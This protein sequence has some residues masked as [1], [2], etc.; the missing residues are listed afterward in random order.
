MMDNAITMKLAKFQNR[1]KVF[2]L[3][4]IF[5]LGTNINALSDR[6]IKQKNAINKLNED[7]AYL[8]K[9]KQNEPTKVVTELTVQLNNLGK[10]RAQLVQNSNDIKVNYKQRVEKEANDEQ[11]KI[12]NETANEQTPKVPNLEDIRHDNSA[13]LEEMKALEVQISN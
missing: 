12:I 4:Q 7:I 5:E 11:Q 8:R 13:I 1:R 9:E 2:Y 3:N 10:E 6:I